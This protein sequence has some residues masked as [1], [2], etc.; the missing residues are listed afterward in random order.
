[1]QIYYKLRNHLFLWLGYTLIN[2]Q[3]NNCQPTISKSAN[4]YI[5]AGC[6]RFKRG[7]YPSCPYRMDS[8]YWTILEQPCN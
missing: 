5:I 8:K 2:T 3:T 6:G 4:D 7:T 1:M